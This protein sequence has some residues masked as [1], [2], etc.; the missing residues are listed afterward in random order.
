MAS[1]SFARK[2]P[3]FARG[4]VSEKLTVSRSAIIYS[5]YRLEKQGMA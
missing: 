2:P 4:Q 5:L 3:P 1:T